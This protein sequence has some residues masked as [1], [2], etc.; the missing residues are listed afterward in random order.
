VLNSPEEVS[1]GYLMGN[2]ILLPRAINDDTT[3]TDEDVFASNGYIME[4][5]ASRRS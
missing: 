1:P 4:D 2:L 3:L 5:G